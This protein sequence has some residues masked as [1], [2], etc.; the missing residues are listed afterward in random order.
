MKVRATPREIMF[1]NCRRCYEIGGRG[2]SKQRE[3]V[4]GE[5]NDGKWL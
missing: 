5:E 2:W 4:R 1:W 3:K